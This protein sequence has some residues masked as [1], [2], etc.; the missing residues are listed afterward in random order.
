MLARPGRPPL[1][2]RSM[3]GTA[4]NM[5]A[6]QVPDAR[7]KLVHDLTAG[8]TERLLEE[9]HPF[10]LRAR[11]MGGEPAGERAMALPELQDPLRIRDGGIHLQPIADN[12]RITE[13]PSS[14]P[15]AIGRHHR[16]V[17]AAIRPPERLPLLE[18]GEPGEAGLVD[19][20]HQPLEQRRVVLQWEAVLLVVVRSMPL[21]AGRDVTVTLG[22]FDS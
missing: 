9:L 11:M 19:L 17:D 16:G 14:V 20:Q 13:Q 21:V 7:E 10:L 18:N 15:G 2:N 6:G 1:Q 8:K 12:A 22:H 4:L 3:H 5:G